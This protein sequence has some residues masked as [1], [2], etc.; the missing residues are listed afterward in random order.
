M[1]SGRLT[2]KLKKSFLVV[3]NISCMLEFAE[4]YGRLHK[5]PWPYQW[6]SL[7]FAARFV[8]YEWFGPQHRALSDA[9]ACRAVWRYMMKNPI[10]Y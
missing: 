5:E 10:I 2:I 9:L 3:R 6:Q 1:T 7:K 4:Y 8:K